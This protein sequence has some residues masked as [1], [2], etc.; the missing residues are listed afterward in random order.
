MKLLIRKSLYSD[1]EEIYNLHILCFELNDRWYKNA[2][3]D[4]IDNSIIIEYKNKIIGVLLQGNFKPLI[5]NEIANIELDI[6]KKQVY[7]IV[8]ICIHPNY[9]NKGL[10]NKLITNHFNL[11]P[12]KILCLCTRITNT[13]AI[14]LYIKMGYTHLAIIKDKYFLPIEDAYFMIYNNK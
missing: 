5:G 14:S 8:M 9:R 13:S 4:Y 6:L 10:A 1:L 7:G 11:N 12:N 3:S 2:I